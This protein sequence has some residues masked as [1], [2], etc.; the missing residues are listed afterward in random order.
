MG[1]WERWHEFRKSKPYKDYYGHVFCCA[2]CTPSQSRYCPAGERLLI[3][4]DVPGRAVEI[5]SAPDLRRRRALIAAC[6]DALRPALKIA[7]NDL[8]KDREIQK[9]NLR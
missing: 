7:V 6:P 2:E 1:H 3:A 8:W 9:E 4:Y 5:M